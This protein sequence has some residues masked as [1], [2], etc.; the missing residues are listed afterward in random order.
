MSRIKWDNA[1]DRVYETGVDRMV[2]YTFDP[3]T[4][5]YRAGVPWNG[6]TAF[7]ESPTGGEPTALYADNIKYLNLI[8]AENYQAT[9][10]SFTYP[11]EF[12]ECNGTKEIAD[13]VRIGQQNR[14]MFGLSYRTLLGDA[15][16]GTDAGYKLHLVYNCI[17][18][19]SERTRT[20]INES[21]EAVNPS[22]SISSTPVV[23]GNNKP[24]SK[25]VIDSTKT[26]FRML[27]MM[28][29]ILYGGQDGDA[30]LP[31]MKDVLAFFLAWSGYPMNTAYPGNIVYP[32][33][34]R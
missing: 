7:N 34:T 29:S 4:G 17:A 5:S 33:A 22:W 3:E 32:R 2:L 13:G 28:E 30:M 6:I 11:E 1:A 24:T 8:S 21:P 26:S 31:E 10:E 27:S 23:L 9:L 16:A 20:S 15:V 18:S 19:P 25:I 12:E 14:H